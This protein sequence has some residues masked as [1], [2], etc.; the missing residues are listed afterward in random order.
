MQ[1]I[2]GTLLTAFLISGCTVRYDLTLRPSGSSVQTE[3]TVDEGLHDEELEVLRRAHGAHHVDTSD[4][5]ST[6]FFFADSK[7]GERWADGFAGQGSW[8]QYH[9]PLGSADCFIECLGGDVDLMTD[10][11]LLQDGIEIVF[12]ML[13]TQIRESL[14][15]HPLKGRIIQVLRDRMLPDA[16]DAAI[17]LWAK[18]ISEQL[19]PV[20]QHSG[21]DHKLQRL[22][23]HIDGKI[24]DAVV[25]FLWQRNWINAD[26]SILLVQDRNFLEV[27]LIRA[28]LRA[29]NLPMNEKSFTLLGEA[30]TQFK[31]STP[32]DFGEVLADTVMHE[33]AQRPRLAVALASSLELFT[34]REVDVRLEMRQRPSQTNGRWNASTKQVV[35]SLDSAPMS[36][37]L[38]T[39]P[40]C[41][42]ATWAYPNAAAQEN[43]FG[44]VALTG[45]DLIAFCLAWNTASESARNEAAKIIDRFANTRHGTDLEIDPEIVVRDCMELLFQSN[46]IERSLLDENAEHDDGEVNEAD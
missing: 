4:S 26:E 37:G 22:D 43:T 39:P 27:I 34:T 38:T 41:W 10:L 13:E 3:I 31:D 44:H 28:A 24:H 42:W 1:K 15:G 7:T 16:R 12:R 36:S 2:H 9:S 40:L 30:W 45:T 8:Q 46:A 21:S 29:L 23:Q 20:E 11:L 6:Q 14:E 17:M 33:M 35:W 5:L 18:T 25:A 19:L 32:R